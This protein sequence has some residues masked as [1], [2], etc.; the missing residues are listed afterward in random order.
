MSKKFVIIDAMAL[1]YK[2]YFAFISRPLLSSKGEPTSA[3]FGFITQLLK[4]LEDFKPDY[5][6]IAFDSKEKTFRH[7]KYENYKSS[8]QAMPDDLIPQIGRIKSII[9][10]MNI[11]LYIL[12]RYEADDIVG[13][14]VCKAE[15]KGLESF[16]VTPDKDYVQLVTDKVKIV[17]PG[18]SSEENIILDKQKVIELYGF[19]P[20]L[21]IDYLALIGDSSDDI[22]GVKGIGEKSAVPLIQ[23]FGTIE[24]IYQHIDEIEKPAIKKK[25]IEG[26][27]NAFLSKDLATIHCQV[28]IEIDFEKAK[29]ENPDFDKLREI[30]VDLEFKNLYNRLLK[31]YDASKENEKPVETISTDLK[32]INRDKTKYQLITSVKKAKELFGE[33]A[34]LNFPD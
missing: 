10:A 7:E 19:E 20:A 34:K 28:P 21:M 22:P 31:I 1:A 29:L 33:F 5:I 27:E 2:A 4:V 18:K 12:P 25:L 17:K 14:A 3:T 26:K 32:T 30:F 6:S 24:N 9:E 13:T 23:K 15:A 16:A 8:R 11:P